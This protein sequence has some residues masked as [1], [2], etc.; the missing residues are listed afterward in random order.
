MIGISFIEFIV[1]LVLLSIGFVL[2]YISNKNDINR[3][4]SKS[5]VV[6]ILFFVLYHTIFD[7]LPVFAALIL[8]IFIGIKFIPI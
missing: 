6:E 5:S 2:F 8:G 3:D 4:Y 1:M 7:F